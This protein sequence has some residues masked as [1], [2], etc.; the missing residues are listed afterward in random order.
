MFSFKRKHKTYQDIRMALIKIYKDTK[1]LQEECEK[2]AANDPQTTLYRMEAKR[3]E[4]L[5]M[6]IKELLRES[7]F[8]V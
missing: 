8:L 7:L 5:A 3:A 1:T 4:K 6:G 2:M